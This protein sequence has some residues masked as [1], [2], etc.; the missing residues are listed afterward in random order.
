M[1][2]RNLLALLVVLLALFAFTACGD[3]DT[4]CDHDADTGHADGEGDEHADCDHEEGE[5]VDDEEGD[6]GH[7]HAGETHALGT[8]VIGGV[9][10]EVTQIGDIELPG[11]AVF[12]VEIAS[13]GIKNVRAWLGLDDQTGSTTER[14][15]TEDNH[16]FDLHIG[17]STVLP[18]GS[19]LWLRIEMED[20]QESLGA[21]AFHSE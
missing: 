16:D 18:E 2:H 8:V 10:C 13:D 12:E 6:G 14:A 17:M 21:V 1:T 7:A 15:I 3:G 4:N 9:E 20:G 19:Q 11:E 5:H